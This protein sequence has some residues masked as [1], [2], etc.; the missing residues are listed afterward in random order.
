MV[1]QCNT[2]CWRAPANAT[3]CAA[4]RIASPSSRQRPL[5]VVG[6][7]PEAWQ[8]YLRF[9]TGTRNVHHIRTLYKRALK[10]T[11]LGEKPQIQLAFGFMRFE[12]EMGDAKSLLEVRHT[13]MPL[14]G[15]LMDELIKMLL[16]DKLIYL[17]LALS[18][19]RCRSCRS[20]LLLVQL[21]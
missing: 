15:A 6:Q 10:Q 2:A 19:S 20:S 1:M 18:C 17:G 3:H 12:R 9:T 16:C 5:S 8:G 4:P 14:G 11:Q 13:D 21:P 7:H